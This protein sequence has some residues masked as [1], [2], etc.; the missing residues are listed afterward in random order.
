MTKKRK[1]NNVKDVLKQI[2]EKEL[3][4]FVAK[5][6]D[7]QEVLDDFMSEFKKYFLNGDSGEAYIDQIDSAFIDAEE[8]FGYISHNEQIHLESVV[9]DA[10]EAAEHFRDNGNYEATIGICFCAIDNGASVINTIDDSLGTIG[11]IIDKSVQ[12]LLSLVD[13]DVSKLDDD[14]RLAFMDRCWSCIESKDLRC[15]DWHTDMY[16][17]LVELANKEEEYT[18]IME[19]LGSDL[20]FQSNY[21]ESKMMSLKKEILLKWKGEEA[22]HQL[23]LDN[24]QIQEFREKII[25]EALSDNDFQRA[26]DLALEGIKQ[27][28]GIDFDMRPIW[29]HWMLRIAQKEGNYDLT[30]KYA[31][32]LYLN[33]YEETGKFYMIL[34]QTIPADQWA[35]FAE[36]LA[37]Q[38]IDLHS[39]NAYADLC[40]FERWNDR[41][42]EYVREM[43][44]IITLKKY[45]SQLLKDYRAEIIDMYIGFAEKMMQSHNRN[46]STYKEMCSYLKH[47]KKIGG[48]DQVT[49]SVTTLRKDYKRCRALLEELSHEKL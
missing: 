15:L 2:P 22:A 40:S 6:L 9:Y 11:S 8:D 18:E 5:E 1:S 47:A 10:L 36:N 44:N 41:L 12:V 24:L 38:A 21:M 29:H 13:P 37:K 28:K 35:E 43:R 3:R 16:D 30:V 32:M 27:D 17:F 42:M 20:E 31:S 45:E 33:P 48:N 34:K 49:E 23:M 39:G 19:A 26:Y 7:I 46:R 25:E 4:K 14:S